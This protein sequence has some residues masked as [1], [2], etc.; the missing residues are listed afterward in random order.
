MPEIEQLQGL[1][2]SR[3]EFCGTHNAREDSQGLLRIILS[4]VPFWGV[5]LFIFKLNL[6]QWLE[7]EDFGS[8]SSFNYTF[9]QCNASLE[10][11]TKI[12]L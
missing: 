1:R 8:T 6:V 10:I 3:L 7:E 5:C 9:G 4:K 2:H 12:E 11:G